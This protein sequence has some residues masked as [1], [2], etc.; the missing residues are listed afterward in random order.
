MGCG[1]DGPGTRSHWLG[2][3]CVSVCACVYVCMCLCVYVCV[4]VCVYVR[5]NVFVIKHKDCVLR[6]GMSLH[7]ASDSGKHCAHFTPCL[8]STHKPACNT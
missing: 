8:V 2:P 4:L 7:I 6:P 3:V 5:V 1:A